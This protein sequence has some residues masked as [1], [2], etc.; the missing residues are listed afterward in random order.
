MAFAADAILGQRP[1]DAEIVARRCAEI[2]EIAAAA[3][4][5]AR[6]PQPAGDRF[7]RGAV[8]RDQVGAHL[9][10]IAMAQGPEGRADLVV[11][12]AVAAL[13]VAF[14]FD[15]QEAHAVGG[16]AV[17]IGADQRFAVIGQ[18]PRHPRDAIGLREMHVMREAQPAVF[19]R[20]AVELYARGAIA[21]CLGEHQR[22]QFG[23]VGAE[24][25][26]I[27]ERGVA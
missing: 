27:A 8:H 2:L 6:A 14:H 13:A 26:R 5:F 19:A 3:L 11:N 16:R 20:L 17:A 22:L 18:R 9:R 1:C 12:E 4:E 23:V 21:A 7:A 24:I 25:M 10:D 15:R